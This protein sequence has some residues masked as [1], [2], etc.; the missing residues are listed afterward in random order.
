MVELRSAS[1]HGLLSH[2]EPTQKLKN[3]IN[4]KL[5]ATPSVTKRVVEQY[6]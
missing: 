5:I 2:S 6:R 4:V 1:V 3:N